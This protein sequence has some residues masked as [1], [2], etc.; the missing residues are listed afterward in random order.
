MVH[1]KVDAD[2]LAAVASP[3]RGASTDVQW[4]LQSKVEEYIDV[5]RRLGYTIS[6]TGAYLMPFAPS[7]D[8]R[9]HKGPLTSKV[10]S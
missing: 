5:R 10:S 4:S 6:T 1:L 7:L 2:R 3:G 8:Q 9:G